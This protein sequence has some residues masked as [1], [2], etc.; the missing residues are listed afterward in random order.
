MPFKDLR[1]Q[2]QQIRTHHLGAGGPGIDMAVGTTLVAAVAEIDLQRC[3]LSALQGRENGLN[4]SHRLH[5]DEADS[6]RQTTDVNKPDGSP[7]SYQWVSFASN[8]RNP[9]KNPHSFDQWDLLIA[10]PRPVVPKKGAWGVVGYMPTRRRASDFPPSF[11]GSNVMTGASE[12]PACQS[13]CKP[14]RSAR[15]H[16]AC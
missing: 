11:E 5:A 14:N 8:P 16:K 10:G 6:S 2:R 15:T 7:L 4:N 1:N 3:E 9:H 12:I 13:T